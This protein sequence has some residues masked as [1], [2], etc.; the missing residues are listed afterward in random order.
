MFNNF[1]LFLM[2]Q[3]VYH[4]KYI[5]NRTG[6]VDPN[7]DPDTM[8]APATPGSASGGKKKKLKKKKLTASEKLRVN[9]Y[10]IYSVHLVIPVM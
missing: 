7:Q 2:F 8:M 10:L 3:I 4:E 6:A 5:F 1:M 9:A